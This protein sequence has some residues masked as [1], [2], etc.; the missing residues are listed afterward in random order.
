MESN[1]TLVVQQEQQG[2]S[3]TAQFYNEGQ[4]AVPRYRTSPQLIPDEESCEPDEHVCLS[5]SPSAREPHLFGMS[6]ENDIKTITPEGNFKSCWNAK[7]MLGLTI[8]NNGGITA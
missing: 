7:H 1:N 6:D 4:Q 2:V 5:R 8:D 3:P